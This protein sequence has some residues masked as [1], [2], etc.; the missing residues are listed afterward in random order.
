MAKGFEQQSG[1]DYTDTFNP[2]I[3]PSTIWII[4]AMA[5]HFNW[6]IRQ[7]Y[8]SNAFLHGTVLEE[9]YMEQ[10]Q[11]F[12]SKEQTLTLSANFINSFMALNRL[13]GQGFTVFLP[14]C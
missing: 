14:Y 4:L 13:H 2:V 3:K 9:V 1:V 8:I 12:I 7:L 11:Y 10:P 5:V 6:P